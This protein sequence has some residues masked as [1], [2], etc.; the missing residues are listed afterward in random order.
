[1]NGTPISISASS[2]KRRLTSP[3]VCTDTKKNRVSGLQS[4]A[5]TDISDLSLSEN[6]DTARSADEAGEITTQH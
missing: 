4:E 2:K 6:M 5:E 1:M 3:D